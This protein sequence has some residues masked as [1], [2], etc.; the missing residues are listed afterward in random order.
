MMVIYMCFSVRYACTVVYWCDVYD[1]QRPYSEFW[2][3]FSPDV[4]YHCKKWCNFTFL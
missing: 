3:Y 4:H 2:Q 1:N